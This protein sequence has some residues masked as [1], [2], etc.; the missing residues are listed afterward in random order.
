MKVIILA[1][2]SSKTWGNYLGTPKHLIKFYGKTL[3]QRTTDL[4]RDAGVE[5]I[6]ITT[7]NKDYKIDGVKI[8][9]PKNNILEVDKMT[10]CVELWKDGGILL[11]GD[12]FFTKEA[13]QKIVKTEVEESNFFGRQGINT[14]L[15]Y[16]VS[17]LFAL[18]VNKSE[19]VI[20]S[21]EI[22]K[23]KLLSK[24]SDIP[25]SSWEVHLELGN[26][27]EIIDDLTDDFDY[28]K[29]YNRFIHY[30]NNGK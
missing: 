30:I 22:V 15:N 12:V 18:K 3:L 1:D 25:D 4:L 9:E 19:R 13:M 23:E 26:K 14:V 24:E 10:S 20:K 21:L 29:D 16:G 28:P 7:H 8:Y 6:Y 17:E 27:L 2:G 5:D 11:W